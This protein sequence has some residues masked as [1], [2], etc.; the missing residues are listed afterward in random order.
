MLDFL[1]II[2]NPKADIQRFWGAANG[3]LSDWQTWR[4]PRGCNW[5]YV[6]AAGAGASG[7]C[8]INSA[9][10][11]GGG[12]GGAGGG[13]TTVLLPAMFVPDI[14][15][16]QCGV[17]GK[18][19]AA[20]V[21][22]AL[23]VIGGSTFVCIDASTVTNNILIKVPGGYGGVG[24]A[25]ATATTGGTSSSTS[26]N[27][28]TQQPLSGRG[29]YTLLS[30]I[31]GF[32]GGTNTTAGTNITLP[33][34][35]V[36]VSGGAGGGGSDTTATAYAGG[37]FTAIGLGGKTPSLNGGTA[38][39]TGTPAGRGDDGMWNVAYPYTYFLGGAG[40]G[41]AS[42]TDATGVAGAGGNGAPGCGGGGAGGSNTTA[43]TLARPGDGGDGFVWIISW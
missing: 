23:P 28:I 42:G 6:L 33:A 1:H 17:G 14:L 40:G 37:G 4:K 24:I 21:S 2:D 7:G 10:T 36:M 25:A 5:I 26:G 20:L 43:T 8:G 16:V 9:T 13:Q 38:G 3:G 35:G 30:S 12:A 29:I 15:F 22:G 19:P 18:Q 31:V 41:G 27:I 11:S 32:A 34:T 39:T